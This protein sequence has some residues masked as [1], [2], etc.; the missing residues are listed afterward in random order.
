VVLPSRPSIKSPY[1]D[2]GD[3]EEEEDES[4]NSNPADPFHLA[5]PKQDTM[6]GKPMP[7]NSDDSLGP[8]FHMTNQ[9]GDFGNDSMSLN[10]DGFTV[11]K[12]ERTAKSIL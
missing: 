5:K 12:P 1:E 6:L 9:F 3:D 7:A 8:S 10:E 11:I 2:N 4:F